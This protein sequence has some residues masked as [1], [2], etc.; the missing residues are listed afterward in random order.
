MDRNGVA[1]ATDPA[2]SGVV[3]FLDS[4]GDGQREPD[5]PFRTTNDTGGYRFRGLFPGTYVVMQEV[6]SGFEQLTPED[7]EGQTFTLVGGSKRRLKFGD[8]R[9]AGLGAANA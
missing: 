8:A 1:D 6:P 7:L 9:S 3:I 4:D 5:E 2:I